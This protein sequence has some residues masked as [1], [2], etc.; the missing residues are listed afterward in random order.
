MQA[1]DQPNTSS[2]STKCGTCNG[3]LTPDPEGNRRPKGVRPIWSHPKRRNPSKPL[4]IEV[5]FSGGSQGSW[6]I[7]SR[8]KVWRWAWDQS[9][10]D[11]FRFINE[12]FRS[13]HS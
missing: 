6:T 1:N 2:I 9:L 13:E 12:G 5:W 11:A 10:G 4:L 3:K 8:G 7:R